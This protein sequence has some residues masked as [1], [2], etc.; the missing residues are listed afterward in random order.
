MNRLILMILSVV[1]VVS[2]S[3]D[4]AEEKSQINPPA[5]IHG[6]WVTQGS[7]GYTFT[8]DDFCT[9]VTYSKVCYKGDIHK[10]IHQESTTDTYKVTFQLNGASQITNEFEFKKIS[11]TQIRDVKNEEILTK[12]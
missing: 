3:K 10:V 6:E 12:K 9:S 8:K 4:K 7:S 2:C 11:D 1:M 5:W